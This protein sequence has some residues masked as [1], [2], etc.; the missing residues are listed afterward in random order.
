MADAQPEAFAAYDAGFPPKEKH[1]VS[2]QLPQF[3]HGCGMPLS[4]DEDCGHNADGSINFDYCQNCCQDGKFLQEC[5]M[6]EI[7]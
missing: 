2:G 6:E 3:C 4:K 5:S 1:L 7:R